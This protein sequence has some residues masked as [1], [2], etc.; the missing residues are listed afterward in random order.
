MVGKRQAQ[1]FVGGEGLRLPLRKERQFQYSRLRSSIGCVTVRCRPWCVRSTLFM[2]S[3]A[4]L[5]EPVWRKTDATLRY[6][7][8]QFAASLRQYFV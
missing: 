3:T 5:R 1:Q 2:H 7:S 8:S 6:D 4:L